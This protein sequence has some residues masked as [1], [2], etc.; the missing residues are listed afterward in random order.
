[1]F[2][3]TKNFS[4]TTFCYNSFIYIAQ[5]IDLN[6]QTKRKNIVPWCFHS[7]KQNINTNHSDQANQHEIKTLHGYNCGISQIKNSDKPKSRKV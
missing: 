5:V 3:I 7:V 1:M 6:H 2:Y 4:F